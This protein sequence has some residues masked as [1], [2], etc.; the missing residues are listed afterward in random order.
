MYVQ[1]WLCGL[2]EIKLQNG[3][4]KILSDAFMHTLST[5]A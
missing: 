5:E 1:S 4:K 2:Y 3:T